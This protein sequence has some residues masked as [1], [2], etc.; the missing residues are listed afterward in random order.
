LTTATIVEPRRTAAPGFHE[1]GLSPEVLTALERAA[2]HTPTPI[3]AAVIP[4]VLSGRDVIGQAQT[5]TGK[6]AAF[7]LPFLN[8]WRDTNEPGPQCLVLVPTRELVV[9][10]AEEAKKLA[11]SRHCRAI[12]IYGG[13]R[14]STQLTEMKKG[15]SIAVGSPGRVIDHLRRGTLSLDRVKYVVLDE[16]DRMLDIGFRPDIEK[17]L[18]RCPQN[19]QTLLLSATMPE[20]VK[21][22]SKR[23]MV[24]PLHV[25]ITPEKLTVDSIRQSYVSVDDERKFDL[26][27]RVLER[28]HVE[29]CIIFCQ[30]KRWAHQLYKDLREHH[31]RVSVMHGDLAQPLR[32]KIMQKFRD[33]TVSILVATDV[34]GRGIDVT[35][36]SHI[37]N[38]DLPDDP[39]NYVHRIG[40]TGRMGKNGVAIAFVTRDQ[41][42][43]LTAIECLINKQ[44]E[45]TSIPD[46]EA[47]RRPE[48]KP[49]PTATATAAPAEEPKPATPVFGRRVR[50][51]SR[52][53]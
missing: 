42:E 36:I 17:I 34:V 35:G 5:G 46:F 7:L 48:P 2:Y 41:G 52:R 9:Q 39:E 40:R 47:I 21:R 14:I 13:Q 25:S 1:L 24:E 50:R 49:K 53:L 6:T 30:R 8:Q 12:P 51:Y 32:E 28:E 11:P 22:L 29:Q 23:Y 20:P 3:Q 19:R 45:R 43:Q 33:G 26:L 31:K 15:Y 38:Y 37:I 16:A 4:E 44:I 18:R 27:L 10:V